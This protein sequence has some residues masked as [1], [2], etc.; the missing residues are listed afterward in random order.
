MST[1]EESTT[2]A[3]PDEGKTRWRRFAGAMIA[4]AAMGAGMVALTAQGV[5]A[6]QFAI[7]G[8][9]FTVTVNELDG[10]GFAQFARIRNTLED[11]P[12]GEPYG[13]QYVVL[14][15]AV[16]KAT[17]SNIC[18]SIDMGGVHMKLTAGKP[19]RPVTADK[20]VIDGDVINGD[21]A[22]FT[23]IDIGQDASTLD[24]VPGVTGGIGIFGQQAER[25][26]IRNL[27]QNNYAASAATFRLPGL[28][29]SFSQSGC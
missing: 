10:D 20:L 14:V 28:S 6:N 18:Q 26:K 7:S 17:L 8:M 23:S 9:P 25:V 4:T 2:T 19:G 13:G 21:L 29:M 11:N 27:R 22:E 5:L 3:S 1:E 16:D 15:S 24:E 12:V